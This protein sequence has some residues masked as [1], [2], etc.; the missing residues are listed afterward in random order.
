M[1]LVLSVRVGGAAA[2]HARSAPARSFIKCVYNRYTVLKIFLVCNLKIVN[3][4]IVICIVL[5][6]KLSYSIII[7][8][9]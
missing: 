3:N 9:L 8:I 5:I 6:S 1:R 2:M 7:Y 4:T